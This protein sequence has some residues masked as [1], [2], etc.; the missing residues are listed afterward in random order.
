MSNLFE[1]FTAL[2]G[3][4]V[5]S[6]TVNSKSHIGHKI[7]FKREHINNYDKFTIIGKTLL[8]GRIWAITVGHIPREFSRHT[9]YALQKGQS[10]KQPFMITKSKP[11]LLLLK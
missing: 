11:L 4:H 1:Y 5:H 2:R 3:F 10:F 8:K 6:N 7:S 9:W